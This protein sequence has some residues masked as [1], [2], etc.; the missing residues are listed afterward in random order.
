MMQVQ[1]QSSFWWTGRH[2][3]T[4]SL[5]SPD[6]A[7]CQGPSLWAYNDAVFTDKDF[8]NINKLAGGTKVE[9]LSKIGRF[10]L[11]FNAVYHLTDVPSFISRSYL[12]IFDPNV[13]HIEKSYS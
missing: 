12:C 3:R 6:M 13:N 7:E 10:G 2:G 8:E 9:D 5:F 1:L 11:G 4:D